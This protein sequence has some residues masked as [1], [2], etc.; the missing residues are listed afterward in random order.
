MKTAKQLQEKYESDFKK[1]QESCKHP[2]I[3]DWVEE[4]WAASHPT[5]NDIKYC[6]V[7]WKVI[8]R[9]R[10]K[11]RFEEKE[12]EDGVETEAVFEGWE[13]EKEV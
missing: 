1:L 7:C 11:I 3:T 2:D 8:E 13:Y 9:K 4:Y 12:T 6:K 5:G 10:P